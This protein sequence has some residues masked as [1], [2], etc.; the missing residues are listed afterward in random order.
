MIKIMYILTTIVSIGFST[1]VF[2]CNSYHRPYCGNYYRPQY[3]RIQQPE[4][5]QFPS[6]KEE[7]MFY[8][9]DGKKPGIVL[10]VPMDAPVNRQPWYN[11]TNNRNERYNVEYYED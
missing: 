2:G 3:Y 1:T 5:M 7:N 4:P 9:T 6:S 11:R 8:L 10:S